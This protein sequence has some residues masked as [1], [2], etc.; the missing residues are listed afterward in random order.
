[1]AITEET[2]HRLYQRLEEV[3]GPEQAATMMAHLP[4]VG[5]ADVATKHDLHQLG[6]RLDLRFEQVDLRIEAA[7]ANVRAELHR[8]LRHAVVAMI[9]ADTALVAVAFAAAG[10]V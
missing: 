1:M 7:T 2:R 5:W 8:D 3:L 6:A 4:P 9:A 10:L